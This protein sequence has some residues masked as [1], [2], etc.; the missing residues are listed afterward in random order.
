MLGAALPA[1][2]AAEAAVTS[3]PQPGLVWTM[4]SLAALLAIGGGVGLAAADRRPEQR[5]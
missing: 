3:V 5:D 2:R 1:M 4:A